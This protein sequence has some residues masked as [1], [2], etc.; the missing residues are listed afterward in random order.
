MALGVA[1]AAV[2]AAGGIGLVKAG[3]FSDGAGDDY[4]PKAVA[5][6]APA[7]LSIANGAAGV[8]PDTPLVLTAPP[9]ETIGSVTVADATAH[10]V[11][12]TYSADRKSWTAQSGLRVSDAYQVTAVTT[13]ASDNG[14]GVQH[15]SF[16]TTS[17]PDSIKFESLF[18][19]DGSTVGVGQPVVL[20]FNEPIH[21]KAAIERAM[22]VASDPP[23]QGSWGWLS[24]ERVDYRPA[25]YWKPGTKVYVT[26]AFDGVNLG[27]GKFGAKDHS[28]A[29]T[30]G[31]D[32]ETLVNVSTDQAV[33]DRDGQQVHSFAVSGGMPGLDTWDGTYAVID[34]AADVTMDS[35][36]AGLGDEYYDPD[37]K[38][39]VHFT[40]S[41][42]YVHSAPW[43][44]GAQG[45]ENVS[46]GC[47]GTNPADAEWFYENTL[48]GD[49][50]KVVGSPRTAAL[51]NGFNDWQLSWT[52]WQGKSAL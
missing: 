3:A 19:A 10:A 33:V 49:V 38:W 43:S 9:G 11:S 14:V 51:G 40:Y 30:I 1:G 2:I 4:T 18:P 34:K 13:N 21:D 46:H 44:V 26:M 36:T 41:G 42:S 7:K 12:G 6:A 45:H 16:Q 24:D 48:P 47:V 17:E 32:Q 28:V 15:S 52:D 50:I 23:Q 5:N 31:R 25:G 22:T 39:D 27:A 29:F 35:R 8:T 37:V 20:S